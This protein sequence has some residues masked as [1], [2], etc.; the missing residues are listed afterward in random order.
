VSRSPSRGALAL[1]AAAALLSSLTFPV[2]RAGAQGNQAPIV[3]TAD[4]LV[5]AQGETIEFSVIGQDPEGAPLSYSVT[6]DVAGLGVNADSRGVH[7]SGV[8]TTLGFFTISVSATDGQLTT[9]EVMQVE[10]RAFAEGQLLTPVIFDTEFF[11]YQTGVYSE[12]QVTGVDGNNGPGPLEYWAWNLPDGMT[13]NEATG[14]VSGTPTMSWDWHQS[15]HKLFDGRKT[16]DGVQIFWI[17]RSSSPPPTTTAPTTTAPPTTIAPTTTAATT[18]ARPTTTARR[19]TTRPTTTR[20][21]TTAAPTTRGATS[22]EVPTTATTAPATTTA[23]ASPSDTRSGSPSP[24]TEA[25]PGDASPVSV[26]P[27]TTAAP[28]IGTELDASDDRYV[29]PQGQHNL[30]LAQN[31][32]R[33]SLDDRLEII[34][35]TQPQ[36]GSIEVVGDGV[37]LDTGT[38]TGE[39]SF[40]Y[41]VSDGDTSDVASV[42]VFV[43]ADT[44]LADT[45]FVPIDGNGVLGQRTD[46]G[47]PQRALPLVRVPDVLVLFSSLNLSALSWLWVLFALV[48]PAL[49]LILARRKSGWAAVCGVERGETAPVQI[50]RGEVQLRHDATNIWVTGRRKRGRAQV[51]TFAGRGWMDPQHLQIF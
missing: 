2:G 51:E 25:A 8:P 23:P 17:P 41:T 34:G 3:A 27:P 50:R 28:P 40:T 1:V 21:P 13:M 38:W 43:T 16:S 19:S 33:R 14:V 29:V 24:S 39:L 12:H 37:V 31:D 35:V 47:G 46:E 26:A 44:G 10:V 36:S 5:F 20:P 49:W 22:T 45:N 7:F 42:T 18:T 32:R 9:T 4:Q 11:Y 15:T 48:T 30:P 6:S